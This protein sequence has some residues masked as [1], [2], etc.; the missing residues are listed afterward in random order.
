MGGF[1][2]GNNTHAH[3]VDNYGGYDYVGIVNWTHGA[4]SFKFGGDEYLQW[5]DRRDTSSQGEFRPV[6]TA[7]VCDSNGFNQQITGESTGT[8]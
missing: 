4:H 5:R 1:S 3:Q 8:R 2:F 6:T 7:G